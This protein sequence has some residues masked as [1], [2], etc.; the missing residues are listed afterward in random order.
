MSK[1]VITGIKSKI[2][3][4]F[5]EVA[6]GDVV[7]IRTDEISYHLD[8]DKYLFCHGVLYPKRGFEQTAREYSESIY[9]NFSSVVG[10]VDKIIEVNDKARICI[11]GSQSAYKGSYDDTY[12]MAKALI[13]QYIERKVLRTPEQQLIG[14]APSIVE[15][16]GMTTR[17]EDLDNL[18]KRKEQHPMKRFVTSREVA[19][20]AHYLLYHQPYVNRTIVRMHGGDV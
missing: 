15:D 18:V 9:K 8:A 4:E 7:G 11:I 17:R 3:Q 10:C 20:M 5:K 19:E 6:A 2:A 12:A 16:A 1:I 14:V 13:H